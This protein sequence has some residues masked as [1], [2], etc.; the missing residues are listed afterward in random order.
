MNIMN[1]EKRLVYIHVHTDVILFHHHHCYYYQSSQS[2]IY[3]IN[4]LSFIHSFIHH[5]FIHSSYIY[6]F[7]HSFTDT[8]ST[9]HSHQSNYPR[10]RQFPCSCIPLHSLR[11]IQPERL[12]IHSEHGRM[13]G[14][15]INSLQSFDSGEQGGDGRR[16][17]RFL[18]SEGRW[19]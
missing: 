13:H 14:D 5:T 8:P 6:S 17:R 10:G 7:T 2:Y 11:A 19:L 18:C 15:G 12:H 9:K 16:R 3:S 4:H 1:F